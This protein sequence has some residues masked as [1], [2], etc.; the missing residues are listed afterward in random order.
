[1]S[2]SRNSK[3]SV[4][5]SAIVLIIAALAFINRQYIYD[6]VQVLAY[7]PSS[8]VQDIVSKSALSDTG[9]FYLYASH[10]SVDNAANFNTNCQRQEAGNA[11][12][13]C[14]NN[15]N[16]YI[17]DVNNSTLEGIKEVTAVHEM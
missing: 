15:H 13:G 6:Q 4:I 3:K 7:S 12:L 5:F 9:K 17:Y 14:Y 16:I 10:A 8:E 2:L 11:I 1:M